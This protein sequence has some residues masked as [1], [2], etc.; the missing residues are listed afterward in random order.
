LIP[1]N[2]GRNPDFC[3]WVLLFFEKGSCLPMGIA[4]VGAVISLNRK[5]YAK[6]ETKA[7]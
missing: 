5:G 7:S 1:F 4:L 6:A 2:K 3:N